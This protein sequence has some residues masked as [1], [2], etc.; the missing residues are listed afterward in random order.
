MAELHASTRRARRFFWVL[1][2]L[3]V[4]ATGMLTDALS[5]P[6]SPATGMRVSVAGLLLLALIA[7]AARI[8]DAI[9]RANAK[10]RKV[11]KS[12]TSEHTHHL[13]DRS[14]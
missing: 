3:S 8:L 9:E 11:P 1:V 14:R 6:A 4:L 7:L 2:A 10:A 13:K 5:S 12:P